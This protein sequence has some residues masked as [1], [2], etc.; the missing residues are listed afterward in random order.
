MSKLSKLLGKPIEC[1]IGGETFE[2]KP[3]TVKDLD[4]LMD[5]ENENK[6]AGALKQIITKTLKNS[7]SDATD[8]E[9]D[10]V[11]VEHFDE[12]TKAILKVNK[13]DEN[14]KGKNGPTISETIGQPT[15]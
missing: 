8:E 6:R 15:A 3:L 2:L 13:L 7:I 4:L 9:I 12:L 10:G 14:P 1:E 5:L 11:A